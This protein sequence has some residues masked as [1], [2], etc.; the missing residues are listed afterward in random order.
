MTSVIIGSAGMLTTI[1]DSGRYGYQRYGMPVAG[2]MD[3]FSY[4]LANILAGNDSDEACLEATITGPEMYFTGDTEI[5]ICGAD[6]GPMK[7]GRP[8]GLNRTIEIKSGDRVSFKGLKRGCRSYI[9]FRGGIDV[10]EVMGS[11]STYIRANTGGVDGRAVRP[12]DKLTLGKSHGKIKR[13]IAPVQKL[14]V[15]ASSQVIRIC[16]GPEVNHF[17]GN[18]IIRFLTS[19]YKVS[20]HSDRMGYRLLGNPL[21]H[22]ETGADIISAGVTMGTIQIPGDG[23]PLILMADR[24]TT[25]GYSRIANVISADLTIVAQLLPGDTV[26]FLEV[27]L[28]EATKL[29]TERELLLKAI[30]KALK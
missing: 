3:T 8:L 25:G 24:Q 20:E 1:Q 23:L 29:Y 12:G 4:R 22:K 9:A 19:E 27:S 15:Y 2:A 11:R 5:A 13:G 7:N 16:P 21:E 30:H 10:P 18:A 17:L 28:A 6:M 26:S 14:P